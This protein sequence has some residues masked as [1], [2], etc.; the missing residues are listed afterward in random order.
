MVPLTFPRL[1]WHRR[2]TPRTKVY[3]PPLLGLINVVT[4]VFLA[5]YLWWRA[6]ASLN[7]QAPFFSWALLIAEGF[8]VLNYLLFAW[9]TRTVAPA[10]PFLPPRPGLSV[11][12]FIPTYNEDLDVL[13]ATITGA[14]GI[15]YP[16]LTWVLDD[17]RRPEVEALARRLGADYLTRPDNLYHKAGNLNHALKHT[18][19]EFIAIL[20]ADMVP[21]PDYLD[22]TLGYFEDEKLA[23]VQM[24]Q[25]FYNQDSIQHDPLSRHW[26]EQTLFFR[27]IQPGKNHTNSAFWTGSPSVMRRKSL[28]DIGGVATETV[29]EDI[30][31]SVRLHS[32]GW[33]SYFLN[34]VLAYGIAPQTIHAFLLQRLRW[35]QG[36][37]QLYRS[38]D[39]PFW[40][41]G[42]TWQQ[43]ISYLASFLAYAE[44]IQKILLISTPTIIILFEIFPMNVDG[45]SFVVH[46]LPY[47]LLTILAN[48]VG[49]RGYFNW[50]QTEKYNLLKTITFLQSFLWLIWPKPLNFKVTPKSLDNNVY[51]K[52]R[53]SL[54]AYMVLF[55]AIIGVSFTGIV[56]LSTGLSTGVP[57][58]HYGIAIIW[59][60]FNAGIIL[61][62]I[63]DVLSK[64]HNRKDYRFPFKAPATL[65]SAVEKSLI[66][67][68]VENISQHGVG[69]KVSDRV[70]LPRDQLSIY[71]QIPSDEYLVLALG[72][73]KVHKRWFGHRWVGAKFDVP[74]EGERKR[75]TELLFVSLPGL[76][77]D[78]GYSPV[79]DK[80]PERM[81]VPIE[82]LFRLTDES[83]PLPIPSRRRELAVKLKTN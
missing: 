44:A 10:R 50:F 40:K 16:H 3:N 66:S 78:R 63:R 6:T 26:H 77:L 5:Y 68:M 27:V 51:K 14:V 8:G 83:F 37:M 33:M 55:G 18:T 13:E 61:L 47:F 58:T 31:T 36:T 46:W 45:F 82:E 59:A 57:L 7:P 41:R 74:S 53:A 11:D 2:A 62:G 72:P 67:V 28:E 73:L 81:A 65:F 22:R 25:E 20:D 9:M 70:E 52:E 48:K 75:L 19:G 12:V 43:R 38:K 76:L 29:T 35:A 64:K 30:H 24:P 54:R 4:V 49:G 1:V 69:F 15:R 23:F 34:E 21:Q 79:M 39:S 71:F 60:V 56:H 80:K 17:G 32:K 42:L